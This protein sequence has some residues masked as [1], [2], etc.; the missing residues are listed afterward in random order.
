MKIDSPDDLSDQ[1]DRRVFAELL[2]QYQNRLYG[3]IY[4]LVQHWED[5]DDIFQQAVLAM[6]KKFGQFEQ[7]SNFAAWA[8]RVAHLE[9][10]KYRR[11]Q[12]RSRIY[13]CESL[14]EKLYTDQATAISNN[15][16]DMR[17]AALQRCIGKLQTRDRELIEH[18]YMQDR[19]VS[20]IAAMLGRS[21]QSVCNSLR[22]IRAAL[23]R[24]VDSSLATEEV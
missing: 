3:Y 11:N 12:Q 21:S 17:F 1:H 7:G 9:V 6:W 8:I 22:R 16:D 19:K 18:N 10:L 24:C 5:T 13:F 15:H 2:A 20:E 23:L 4:A 14:V